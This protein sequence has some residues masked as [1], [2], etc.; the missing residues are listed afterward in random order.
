MGIGVNTLNK[1]QRMIYEQMESSD[2]NMFITGKAGTG[3]SYLLKC[4]LDN[5]KKNV[6]VIA[7][8]GIAA[9]NVGG[10]TIHRFFGLKPE[11]QIPEKIDGSVIYGNKRD[12]FRNLD[13]I[14]IDE[15]SMVRADLMDTIDYIL[16]K[17]NSTNIPFGGKQMVLFGDLFQLP[18]VVKSG[19]DEE[20]YLLDKYGGFF[21]FDAPGIKQDELK[22]YELNEILRQSDKSLIDVLNHVRE[23]EQT[24]ADLTKLNS[25]VST[26]LLRTYKDDFITLTTTNKNAYNVNN[27]ML[28]QIK[29]PEHNYWAYVEG[30]FNIQ[31]YPTD[32]KLVLKEGAHIMMLNNDMDRRW[33]NGSLATVV[34]CG[35]YTIDVKISGGEQIYTVYKNKWEQIDYYYDKEKKK[36]ESRVI[37]E[38]N[39]LPVKMAWAITI[40]KSQGKTY[41]RV[42]VDLGSGAFAFGQTYVAISRIKSL[43]GLYLKRPI[44]NSDI[45]VDKTVKEYMYSGN[46]FRFSEVEYA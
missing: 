45:K 38:F 25:R 5:T 2:E 9:L 32:R 40:H 27:N 3:K 42:E 14:V 12:L 26:S 28:A 33:V 31:D 19:T 1:E 37:G 8:T 21:F 24:S 46:T 29:S 34:S 36:I 17:A 4:F 39:Q 11:L 30:E 20:K 15:I 16:R 18:P 22:R 41:D 7:P 43:D 35:K 10:A 23:G 6:V 13:T 44:R